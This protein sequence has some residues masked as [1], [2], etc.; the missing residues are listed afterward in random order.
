MPRYAWNETETNQLATLFHRGLSFSLIGKEIGKSK[1]SV[2]SRS[3]RIGLPHRGKVIACERTPPDPVKR[4]PRPRTRETA[5]ATPVAS[6]DSRDYSCTIYELRDR[7]CRYPLWSDEG[8]GERF[9]CGKPTA[10]LSEGRPYCAAHARMTFH[11]R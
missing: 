5:Q 11:A 2:I 8:D 6:V 1:N 3:K 7:S 4:S 10:R 9:Y